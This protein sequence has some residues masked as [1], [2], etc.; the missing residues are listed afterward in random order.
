[1]TLKAAKAFPG[2]EVEDLPCP[3]HFETQ[4]SKAA[5]TP[6]GSGPE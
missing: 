5:K 1:M 2:S 4:D 6:A 3:F